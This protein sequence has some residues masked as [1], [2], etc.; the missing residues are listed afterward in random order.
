MKNFFWL[1]MV[2]IS[3]LLPW[4][5]YAR[6]GLEHFQARPPTHIKAHSATGPIGLTPDQIRAVYNLPA[7]GGSGT[8]AIVGA[9]DAPTIEA[10]LA[11]FSK[12]FGL[13]VCSSANGCF[14][15]HLMASKIKSNTGWTLELSMDTQWAHAIAPDAKIL[16]VEA[17][18]SNGTN[19]IKALDYARS[20]ADVVAISMSWGGPEFAAETQLEDHFTSQ[21]GATFFASSGDN[22][23]GVSWPAVSSHVVGVGG[24][25]L[26]LNAKGDL[27]SE[28]AWTGSGGGVSVY[29][30]QPDFQS[31]YNIPRAKGKRAV[32]DVAYNADP[33][34]GVAVY[35]SL[36][37]HGQKGWFALGGTSAGAPQWA[38][39]KALG[40]SAS[41]QQF[42]QD[43]ASTN[44]AQYFRDILSGSNG[45]CT[46]YCEARKHYDY[47]TGLGSP[48]R[49]SF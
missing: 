37:L 14:E 23:A 41:N 4:P 16:L 31:Q 38:A 11:V 15:K 26:N 49:T 8:I 7:H 42:Y 9:Y 6:T 17:T 30:N 32:P 18:N 22:G 24:T 13:P 2:V 29:I 36:G 48:L 46:Y 5:S 21:Y 47:I 33:R 20:R 44:H 39:I 27:S 35:D 19:L 34:S 12:Q 3:F 45:D 1:G 25:T 28:T 43:K 40:H 10:D